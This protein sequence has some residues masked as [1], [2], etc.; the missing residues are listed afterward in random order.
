VLGGFDEMSYTT[1]DQHHE[2]PHSGWPPRKSG[3]TNIAAILAL[4]VSIN[5]SGKHFQQA[6]LI[7]EVA[8]MLTKTGMDPRDVILEITESVAMEGAETTIEILT[9]LKKLGVLL[10][11]DDFGTGF[12]SLSY[13]KRFPVD[14]LKI[15]KSFVD[16]IAL[17]G[18]DNAIVQAI[19]SL[20]HALGLKVIA[21]G[22]ETVEQEQELRALGSELGQGFF[23]SV[24]LSD[25][26]DKGL[27]KLL[28]T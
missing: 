28:K 27:P 9:R 7:E 12:S 20:G 21:E 24:P 15:D 17:K 5:L 25:D 22:V 19:I 2:N 18:P 10:A 16:G 23:Y 11:I 6:T 14:L 4:M 3:R 26:T 13:L 8:D 1:H